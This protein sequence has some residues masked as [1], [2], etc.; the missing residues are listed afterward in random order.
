MLKTSLS[1]LA[2]IFASALEIGATSRKFVDERSVSW[3]L[4]LPTSGRFSCLQEAPVL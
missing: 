2:P 1:A 3:T 4:R